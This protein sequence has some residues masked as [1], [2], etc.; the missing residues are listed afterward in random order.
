MRFVQ[1]L[2]G[3]V[4]HLIDIHERGGTRFIGEQRGM[5]FFIFTEY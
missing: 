4:G 3:I 2:A 1:D 5:F